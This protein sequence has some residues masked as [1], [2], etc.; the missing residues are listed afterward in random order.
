MPNKLPLTE[1]ESDILAFVYGYIDDN[2][3]SP[4]RQE[5]ADK[6]KMSNQAASYFINQLLEKGKVEI[7]ANKWRNIKI[8]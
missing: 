7:S 4:T 3:Y 6:F 1:K 2:A 5:I 8:A